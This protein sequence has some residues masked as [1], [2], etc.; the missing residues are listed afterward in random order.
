[1]YSIGEVAEQTGITAYT[2]RYYEQIGVLPKATREGGK[3]T[4]SESELRFVHFIHGLKQTGMK[5]ED[6]AA[7]TADGCILNREAEDPDIME[8]AKKRVQLLEEHLQGVEQQIQQLLTVRAI[9]EEKRQYYLKLLE[10]QGS[11]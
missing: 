11:P 4:Y 9:A 2:L 1:L 3:R 10:G 6:I 7:F 5:L 8:T